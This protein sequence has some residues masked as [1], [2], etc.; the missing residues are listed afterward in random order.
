MGA[1]KITRSRM[2]PALPGGYPPSVIDAMRAAEG[3]MPLDAALALSDRHARRAGRS[4]RFHQ[5][6]E[7]D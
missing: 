4:G 7:L 6:G 1:A 5:T 3:M 2:P